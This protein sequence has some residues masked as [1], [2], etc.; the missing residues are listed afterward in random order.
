MKQ[1]KPFFT[2]HSRPIFIGLCLGSVLYL[3]LQLGGWLTSLGAQGDHYATA[4]GPVLAIAAIIVSVIGILVPL[5]FPHG[6]RKQP[7]PAPARGNIWVQG[8]VVVAAAVL[9]LA[10]PLGANAAVFRFYSADDITHRLDLAGNT[11]MNQGSEAR[12]ILPATKHRYLKFNIRLDSQVPTGSCVIP[13]T[14]KVT[15]A[16]KNGKGSQLTDVRSGEWRTLELGDM[17]AGA[18]LAIELDLPDPYCVVGL[19][20]DSAQ[21][22]K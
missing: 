15:P 13:A 14:M 11:A 21:Y 16:F 9:A 12:I 6:L 19:Q 20:V 3:L 4:W 2:T 8:G 17:Q 1:L 5:F 18:A 22:Y 7:A 10:I